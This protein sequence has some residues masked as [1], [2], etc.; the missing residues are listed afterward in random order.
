[1]HILKQ[2]EINERRSMLSWKPKLGYLN[3]L[4]FEILEI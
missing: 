4:N 3:K 2:E 1:M